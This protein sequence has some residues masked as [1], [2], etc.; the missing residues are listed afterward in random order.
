[1]NAVTGVIGK[2]GDDKAAEFAAA[3]G[4]E[5]D[6]VVARMQADSQ[7][8][9]TRVALLRGMFWLQVVLLFEYA[10]P[11]WPAQNRSRQ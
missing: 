6:V 4:A 11:A 8:Y 10:G 2:L 9:Q 5:K 1:V 3:A 7:A